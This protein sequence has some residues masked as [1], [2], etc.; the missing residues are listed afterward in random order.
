M[1]KIP[2]AKGG[3]RSWLT[4][5][6]EKPTKSVIY[7]PKL[8]NHHDRIRNKENLEDMEQEH[9]QQTSSSSFSLV[10]PE[11]TAEDYARFDADRRFREKARDVRVAQR[12]ATNSARN[13]LTPERHPERTSGGS[14]SDQY[15]TPAHESLDEMED[16]ETPQTSKKEENPR[17]SA[18]KTPTSRFS[19]YRLSAGTD[20]VP[21]SSDH[22]QVY[23]NYLSRRLDQNFAKMQEMIFSGKPEDRAE[24]LAGT[25]G[26]EKYK[27]I[28]KTPSPKRGRTP[29]PKYEKVETPILQS[30]SYVSTLVTAHQLHMK[31]A[32]TSVKVEQ[33]M[34]K[35]ESL[36]KLAEYSKK[37]EL[38]P[39]KKKTRRRESDT[40]QTDTSGYFE[41]EDE[42]RVAKKWEVIKDIKGRIEKI[43]KVQQCTQ[44]IVTKKKYEW[45]HSDKTL[46]E[47]IDNWIS[48]PFKIFDRETSRQKLSLNK[49]IIEATKQFAKVSKMFGKQAH[50][51][52]MDRSRDRRRSSSVLRISPEIAPQTPSAS[53]V[54]HSSQASV[55]PRELQDVS[56]Q[57]TPRTKDEETQMTQ[58]SPKSI[59]IEPLDLSGLNG[60]KRPSSLVGKPVQQAEPTIQ[61]ADIDAMLNGIQLLDTSLETIDIRARPSLPKEP[62]VDNHVNNRSHLM[63]DISFPSA[64]STP[65]MTPRS[66]RASL[67]SASARRL[68][69]GIAHYLEQF[70]KE[71]E[72]LDGQAEPE[73]EI[74]VEQ[75]EKEPET[76]KPADNPTPSIQVTS[77]TNSADT[78]TT[79]TWSL[80]SFPA[81]QEIK[82]EPE[83]VEESQEFDAD[84]T[85]FEHEREDSEKHHLLQTE[86]TPKPSTVVE[87]VAEEEKPLPR[88]GEEEE[89]DETKRFRNHDEFEDNSEEED[90]PTNVT[91]DDS[92][93]DSMFLLND[94]VRKTMN[95]ALPEYSENHDESKQRKMTFAEGSPSTLGGSQQSYLQIPGPIMITKAL[96]F[97]EN[98][99]GVDWVE[100]QSIWQPP[101]FADLNM[102]FY[103]HFDYFDSFSTL[104]WGSTVELMNKT[105]LKFGKKLTTQQEKNFE[106][107]AL[108]MMRREFGVESKENEWCRE[109]KLTNKL[110]GM[111]PLE[112]DWRYD[113][114]R[115]V[116]EG[117]KQRY[118]W[119]QIQ[120]KAIDQRFSWK[121]LKN[122]NSMV[123]ENSD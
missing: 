67:D 51:D 11:P 31:Y 72:T 5:N 105:Y 40:D 71:Q 112:L 87:E 3:F 2:V 23:T 33:Q 14:A 98:L 99:R 48:L 29:S 107:E 17:R 25:A 32:E 43:N 64:P 109:V 4:K 13:S 113:V 82:Q 12:V 89:G 65:E 46:F 44:D 86:E 18:E 90:V 8:Q 100:A 88:P 60:P 66:G 92:A 85:Q 80:E 94:K 36:A 30:S 38:A 35:A 58:R 123:Q 106:T 57:M 103:D 116:G 96:E 61:Q 50:R 37:P 84:A 70:K 114:R 6:D 101:S 76:P 119:Q 16:F 118:Q 83:D 74:I 15:F 47:N 81:T 45:S 9:R 91:A 55:H 19:D 52:T 104:L 69:E 108:E 22:R 120:M 115:G 42:I 41:L 63:K 24:E 73:Q 59:G 34:T 111:N 20:S 1:S 68:S 27:H 78:L 121:H 122:S 10:N 26:I 39:K 7:E 97:Q 77:P 54:D 102:D 21:A 56:T 79:P 62:E 49:R 53:F 75:R 95:R 28:E 110:D 93:D 117:E